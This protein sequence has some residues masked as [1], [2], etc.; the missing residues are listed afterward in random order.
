M[1]ERKRRDELKGTLNHAVSILNHVANTQ[2][3]MKQQAHIVFDNRFRYGP[4]SG[5]TRK[6]R[7]NRHVMW[8]G[9]DAGIET[10]MKHA[11]YEWWQER[12]K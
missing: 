7:A 9:I 5:I 4:K 11:T 1:T 12:S 2:L 8:K 6:Q 3:N 10:L